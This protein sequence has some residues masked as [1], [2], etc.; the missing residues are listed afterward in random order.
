MKPYYYYTIA[1][2]FAASLF[3]YTVTGGWEFLLAGPIILLVALALRYI[4]GSSVKSS[5]R[6]EEKR[7]KEWDDLFDKEEKK[8]RKNIN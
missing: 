4:V 3:F 5:I 2:G 6:E 7:K 1:I 8:F